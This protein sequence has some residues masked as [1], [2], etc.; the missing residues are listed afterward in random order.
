MTTTAEPTGTTEVA[1]NLS[2]ALRWRGLIAVVL[3][4][5]GGLVLLAIS[6]FGLMDQHTGQRI[7][8]IALSIVLLSFGGF[9][10]RGVVRPSVWVVVA[11]A[12]LALRGRPGEFHVSWGEL[13]Q[14]VVEREHRSWGRSRYWFYR[15]LLAPRAVDE[16]AMSHPEMAAR[17]GRDH[18]VYDLGRIGR[19]GRKLDRALRAHA[20]AV[21]TGIR[22]R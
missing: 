17:R 3:F 4:G 9:A 10:L 1:V 18:Y 13:S 20:P 8:E 14:V 19:A 16:F 12:G 7:G 22:S 21:F 2:T 6:V 15:L 5:G 11:G